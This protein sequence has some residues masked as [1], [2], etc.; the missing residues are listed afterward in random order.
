M[1]TT[2]LFLISLIMTAFMSGCNSDNNNNN[3][4][5]DTAHQ[6]PPLQESEKIITIPLVKESDLQ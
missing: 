4:S 3:D 2:L 5:N 1:K 6:Y